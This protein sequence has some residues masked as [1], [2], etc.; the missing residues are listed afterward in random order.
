MSGISC[1]DKG[2]NTQQW[3]TQHGRQKICSVKICSWQNK[4]IN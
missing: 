4:E 3:T 1:S 2:T